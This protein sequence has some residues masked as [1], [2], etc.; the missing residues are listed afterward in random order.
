MR[1]W[2]E[3]TQWAKGLT[4]FLLHFLPQ[5]SRGVLLGSQSN[6]FRGLAQFFS[7]LGKHQNP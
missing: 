5:A 2:P 6:P 3:V 4:L 7:S 1:T